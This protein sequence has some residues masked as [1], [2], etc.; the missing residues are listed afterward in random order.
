MLFFKRTSPHPVNKLKGQSSFRG[1]LYGKVQREGSLNASSSFFCRRAGASRL[2][3]SAET[4]AS[5]LRP[6]K[7]QARLSCGG[8][9][10]GSAYVKNGKVC[11]F[12]QAPPRSYPK[13]REFP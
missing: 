12:R 1:V 3:Q 4:A 2:T 8:A 5:S 6:P 7:P 10:A 11:A 13:E 9:E